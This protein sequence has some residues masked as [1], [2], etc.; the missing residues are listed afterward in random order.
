ML[1]MRNETP[2][3]VGHMVGQAAGLRAVASVGAATGVRMAD[4]ALAAVGHA[5]GAMDEELQLAAVGIEHLV[6]VANLRQ[7][8]LPGQHHLRKAHILQKLGLGRVTDVGLGAGVQLDRGQIQFQQAHVLDDQDIGAS[9][10]DVP[11]QL[12]CRLEFV[13]AQD[14]V[15]R[16]E[17]SAVKAMGFATQAFNVAQVVAGAGAGAKGGCADVDG[18]GTVMDR[19]DANVGIARRGQQLNL[20]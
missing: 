17:D 16:D 6:N 9:V 2:L 18:I 11:C 1:V 4:V 19:G 5:Q 8:E 10:V 3:R 13:I 20:V 14:G 12:A 7:R 15:E